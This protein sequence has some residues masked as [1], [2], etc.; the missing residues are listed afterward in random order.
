MEP[1]FWQGRWQAGQI[2]FHR[3][4]VNPNLVTFAS[5]LDQ[6]QPGKRLYVPLAGK[7]LDLLF[8]ERR[9]H[10]VLACELVEQAVTA[11]FE[12]AS[13]KP[14]VEHAP[15]FEVYRGGDIT[16][17]QGNAFE[18]SAEQARSM[19][20]VAPEQAAVDGIMDRA[21]LVAILPADR[22]RYAAGLRA[23]LTRG[24]RILLETLEHDATSAPPHSVSEA[25]VE[26]LF[27]GSFSIEKLREADITTD[28]PNLTAKG[29]TF[30]REKVFGLVVRDID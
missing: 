7:S 27:G 17:A 9:G 6:D 12:E 5:W 23:L 11:F 28:S 30:V 8:L 15:P 18:L 4:E 16:F 21:A 20:H 24:G 1:A 22:V 2:G 19:L 3:T 25:E 14:E 26:A 10:R 13:R 29:A